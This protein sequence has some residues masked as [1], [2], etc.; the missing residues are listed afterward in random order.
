MKL[1][2]GFVSMIYDVLA[3][4]TELA[5]GHMEE[6]P[7]CG[8]S[9]ADLGEMAR[10]GL[11]K[12]EAGKITLEGKI[13]KF[14]KPEILRKHWLYLD[15]MTRRRYIKSNGRPIPTVFDVF[16]WRCGHWKFSD[17]KRIL[18]AWIKEKRLCRTRSSWYTIVK[19]RTKSLQSYSEKIRK[20]PDE[21][22]M[23]EEYF[24]IWLARCN[25]RKVGQ[26]ELYIDIINYFQD[27]RR[28]KPYVLS[29]TML[30][31]RAVEYIQ[32]AH[33]VRIYIADASAFCP[34]GLNKTECESHWRQTPGE[35][36]YAYKDWKNRD[37]AVRVYLSRF[38]RGVGVERGYI[39]DI[40]EI[41]IGGPDELSGS[42]NYDELLVWLR[43]EGVLEIIWGVPRP[44]RRAEKFRGRFA[45][46]Y[47]KD[48]VHYIYLEKRFNY[49]PILDLNTYKKI[50][51][52]KG[53]DVASPVGA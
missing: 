44:G 38:L 32:K 6:L 21:E 26:K 25:I 10:R 11:L 1:K 19:Q 14:A 29:S 31:G 4:K 16:R 30:S 17:H 52:P 49:V 13:L 46:I 15:P 7:H 22:L 47:E 36:F 9:E 45:K 2:P 24:K 42:I 3:L 27:E 20:M 37:I 28:E 48:G 12:I 35:S 40:D 33:W 53:G 51:E 43:A 41:C 5:Y 50:A 8:I 18:R 39:K 34:L 23:G